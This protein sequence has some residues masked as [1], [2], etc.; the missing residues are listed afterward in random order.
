MGW[1]F[2]LPDPINI[3]P[4]PPQN[5]LRLRCD[6]LPTAPISDLLVPR[7]HQ[8]RLN[9]PDSAQSVWVGIFKGSF[10]ELVANIA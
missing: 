7:L 1:I 9:G 2:P 3:R 8:D 5:P 4:C 6:S 10:P